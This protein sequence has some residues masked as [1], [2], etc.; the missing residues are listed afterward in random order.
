MGRLIG[1]RLSSTIGQQVI[2]GS[3]PG[4]GGTLAER[5][6]RRQARRLH[7]PGDEHASLAISPAL[8]NDIGYDPAIS[9]ARSRCSS[10]PSAMIAGPSVSTEALPD[11]VAYAKANPGRL[12]VGVPTAHRRI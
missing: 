10:V 5:G 8:Y 12:N 9:V 1:Q 7:S 4:A 11:L 2:V 3:R 6:R